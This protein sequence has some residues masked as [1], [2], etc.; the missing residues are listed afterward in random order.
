MAN[1]YIIHTRKLFGNDTI[2]FSEEGRA[3]TLQELIEKVTDFFTSFP[4]T[5]GK[6]MH[7]KVLWE[8]NDGQQDNFLIPANVDFIRIRLRDMLS[9]LGDFRFFNM[10][11]VIFYYKHIAA[12]GGRM[13][14][15]RRRSKSKSKSKKITPSL[16]VR[17]RRLPKKS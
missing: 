5:N 2:K 10:V 11:K 7:L 14:M 3:D 12:G 4:I 1:N 15:T 9:A 16:T 8:K 13:L 17:N 6:I